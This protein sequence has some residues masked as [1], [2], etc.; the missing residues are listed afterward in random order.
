M[1]SRKLPLLTH[2]FI[3]GNFVKSLDNMQGFPNS[4]KGLGGGGGGGGGGEESQIL[5]GDFEE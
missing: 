3:C 5:L 2:Y 1:V 4:V